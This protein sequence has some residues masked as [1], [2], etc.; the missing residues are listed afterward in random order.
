MSLHRQTLP[1]KADLPFLAYVGMETDLIFNRGMDLPGFASYPLLETKEGRETLCGYFRQLMRIAQT[2]G[3]GVILE[4]PTWVANADRARPLGYTPAQLADFNKAAIALMVDMRNEIGDLPTVIS[5]NIGPRD[6][7]YAPGTQMTA[8]DAEAYHRQQITTLSDTK[9][10]IVSAYTLAYPAEAIGIVNAA[11]SCDLPVIVAFTV[12][13]D[14]CL[15]TGMSLGDAICA[16]DDAT[17]GYARYFMINCAHP[18]HFTP[19]LD[20][21]P[22]MR[23]LQG[24]VANASRCSHA[25][26]DEATELDDGNPAELADQLAALRQQNPSLNVLG[27]CCGTDMRHM[28]Q[29]AQ[30]LARSS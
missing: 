22:W 8:K 11:R 9:V 12:E 17:D 19:S 4:S 15:P 23:R 27:G 2:H 10:D 25:E 1:Q 13:T 29:L 14:S 30:R 3:L 16:V 21:A 6:D 7:A 24:V 26:L 5:A 18:D 28:E 20:D